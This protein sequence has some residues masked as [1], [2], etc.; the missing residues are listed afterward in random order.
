MT[1]RRTNEIKQNT[2]TE[3]DA[4]VAT[5]TNWREGHTENRDTETAQQQTKGGWWITKEN[6]ARPNERMKEKLKGLRRG[7]R[8]RR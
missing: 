4:V 7:R 3:L 6:R 5:K 2:Y 8:G 1:T